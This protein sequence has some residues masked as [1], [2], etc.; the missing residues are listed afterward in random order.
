MRESMREKESM[1]ALKGEPTA[2][3]ISLEYTQSWGY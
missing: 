2:G 3:L 1:K